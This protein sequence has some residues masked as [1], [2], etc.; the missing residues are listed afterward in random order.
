MK[1][2]N[3]VR[4]LSAHGCQLLREGRAHSVWVNPATGARETIPRHAEIKDQ[5]ARRIAQRLG[6]PPPPG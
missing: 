6:V 1:R 4:H 3:L 5:L 2:G